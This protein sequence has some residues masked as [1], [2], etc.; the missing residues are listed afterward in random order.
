MNT[1]QKTTARLER[2]ARLYEQII[3]DM[4]KIPLE[5]L[6]HNDRLYRMAVLEHSQQ[7]IKTFHQPI[8]KCNVQSDRQHLLSF[9]QGEDNA[10]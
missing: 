3:Q 9:I 5:S 8:R 10:V 1:L 2:V 4:E 7:V 6:S